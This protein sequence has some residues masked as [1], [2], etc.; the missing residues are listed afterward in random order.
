MYS[1]SRRR[2]LATVLATVLALTVLVAAQ[3]ATM[4]SIVVIEPPPPPPTTRPAAGPTTRP[5]AKPAVQPVY[6][7]RMHLAPG[8]EVRMPYGITDGAGTRWDIQ[9]NGSIGRC[10]NYAFSQSNGFQIDNRSFGASSTGRLS[11]DRREVEVGPAIYNGIKVHRRIRV[12][13]DL[14]V[15]RWLEIFENTTGASRQI[16]VHLYTSIMYNIARTIGGSGNGSLKAGDWSFITINQYQ[17]SRNVP[18]VLHIVGDGRGKVNAA[19]QVQNGRLSVRRT[20]TVPPR[21]AVALC[22]FQALGKEKDLVARMKDWKS[23]PLMK[24]LPWSLQQSIVNMRG[25]AYDEGPPALDRVAIADRVE[26]DNG[27]VVMGRLLN[28]S[29]ALKTAWGE[30]TVPA[31]QVMG[32]VTQEKNKRRVLLVMRD[33]QVVSGELVEKV[34]QLALPTGGTLQIPA[35]RTRQ[36]GYQITTAKPLDPVTTGPLVTLQSGDRLAFQ[37]GGPALVLDTDHGQVELP[38]G[39]L[40]SIR[41]NPPETFIDEVLFRNGSKLSGVLGPEVR[42]FKLRLGRTIEVRR[43]QIRGMFWT[44]EMIDSKEMAEVRLR[45]GDELIGLLPGKPLTLKSEFGTIKI[46]PANVQ[47]IRFEAEPAG[48][49]AMELWDGSTLRGALVGKTLAFVIGNGGPAIDLKVAQI[50][51]LRLPGALPPKELLSKIET[52]IGQLGSEAFEDRQKATTELIR[53]GRPAIPSLNR[54]L[55]DPDLEVRQRAKDILKK[56]QQAAGMVPP[57]STSPPVPGVIHLHGGR[58]IAVPQQWLGG[59]R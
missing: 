42:T 18:H 56:I 9:S 12:Y 3:M 19:V 59:L 17:G 1:N 4:A 43:E 22:H 20:I 30:L 45:N 37:P 52:L 23:A 44:S 6:P 29:F 10:A 38:P 26:L 31:E 51:S 48:Q 36:C 7:R 55:T 11:A 13:K 27:D 15:C 33:G 39:N 8:R 50:V 32:L 57:P 28:P 46:K 25:S 21:G 14:P 49:V 24:D 2:E 41:V 34:L 16:Q 47:S 54:R 58:V 40:Q 53:I 5:A 35:D